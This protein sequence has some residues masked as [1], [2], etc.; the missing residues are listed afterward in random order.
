[1][2]FPLPVLPHHV[3]IQCAPS[4][5][6]WVSLRRS[7]PGSYEA[8]VN[9]IDTVGKNVLELKSS[10]PLAPSKVI[11]V[12]HREEML[13]KTLRLPSIHSKELA[14]M[15]AFMLPQELPYGIA[16][17]AYFFEVLGARP[18]GYTEVT[19]FWTPRKNVE[20]KIKFLR[21]LGLET[22]EVIASSQA[23]ALYYH[24]LRE[25]NPALPERAGLMHVENQHAEL[26]IIDK[27]RALGS[28]LIKKGL[29][30]LAREREE[31]I[32]EILMN[33]E[34]LKKETALPFQTL[35]VTGSPSS[36]DWMPALAQ[37]LQVS[38]QPLDWLP[39]VHCEHQDST[40][41]ALLG[42]VLFE[43]FPSG[44][45]LPSDLKKVRTEEREKKAVRHS[46][47]TL[48]LCVAFSLGMLYLA[49]LQNEL[50]LS[51]IL[52]EF[53]ALKFK[54]KGA[55]QMAHELAWMEKIQREKT[56][57]LELL[58][59]LP[60][61]TPP[62][63]TLTEIAYDKKEGIRLRGLG[64]THQIIS[65]YLKALK[66]FPHIAQA[67]FDFSQRRIQEGREYFEF[68]ISAKMR[69]WETNHA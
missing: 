28:R 6:R 15:V 9:E 47:I 66:S 5:T 58:A 19:V 23:L 18:D 16:E 69:G 53:K 65:R 14:S 27:G 17:I 64:E 57:P 46:L 32:N 40:A 7:G 68:Q 38:V 26:V 36:S 31:S 51:R 60:S 48:T 21:T 3:A 44:T 10:L 24:K 39:K 67:V 63:I 29:K 2:K 35:F 55:I 45:L 22:D 41:I 54:T 20:E 8:A 1:M 61:L 30:S 42:A 11:L 25:K 56:V 50:H 4:V 59:S 13:T 52:A 43:R 12:I 34:A 62:E 49:S 37:A 33:A